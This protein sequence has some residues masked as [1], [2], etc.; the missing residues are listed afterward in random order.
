VDVDVDPDQVDE[1]ARPHRPAR[2]VRHGRVERLGR[3]TRLVEHPDAVVQQG[4][5]DTVDDEPRGV[6]ARDGHLAELR[7]DGQCCLDRVVGGELCP[8]DLDERHQR[9]R[10]EEVHPDDPLGGR[11]RGGDLRHGQGGGV[12]RE[13][14]VRAADPLQLGEERALRVE[15]LDDRLDHEVA[16][17]KRREVGR[18]LEPRDRGI[19]LVLRALSL[20]HLAREEVADPRRGGL[21]ELVRDLA[22]DDGEAR[23]DCDLR[24]P[25]AHRAEPDHPDPRDLHGGGIYRGRASRRRVAVAH[26]A[27]YGLP[28]PR[29]RGGQAH[30]TSRGT[31]GPA[32]DRADP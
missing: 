15:L 6:V 14:G 22:A 12:R 5:E 13:D 26:P 31:H 3:H 32:R 17:G 7:D 23:L 25:R 10:V 11:R 1:R 18:G 19:P 27:R 28:S 4:D 29:Q 30:D 24:D 9:G 20:L 8:D 16:V 2:A 21:A